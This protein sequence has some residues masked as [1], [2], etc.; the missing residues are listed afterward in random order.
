MQLP[1]YDHKSLICEPLHISLGDAAVRIIVGCTVRSLICAAALAWLACFSMDPAQA[2]TTGS[3]SGTVTD[4]KTHR[5]IGGVRVTAISPTSTLKTTADKSGFFSFIGVSPD[6]YTVSFDVAGYTPGRLTGVAVF[7]DQ[8]AS[9]SIELGLAVRLLGTVT[10]RGQGGAFQPLQT[11]NTYTVT[12]N[13]I[14]L[15][16]GKAGNINETSLLAAL[17]GVSLDISGYPVLRGGRQNEEGYEFEGIENTDAFA[18][19]FTNDL[20]MSGTGELQ[21]TPG[22]GD[23]SQG[24]FGT[25]IINLV[26]KRGT[27]PPFGTLETDVGYPAYYHQLAFEYGV[28]TPNSRFSDYMSFTGVRQGFQLGYAGTD[29]AAINQ[30]FGPQFRT[31]DE[32]VNNFFYKFGPNNNQALQLFVDWSNHNH[33]NDYGG[34]ST[35]CYKTCDHLTLDT[36]SSLSGLTQAQIQNMLSVLAPGAQTQVVQRLSDSGDIQIRPNELYKLQYFWNADPSTFVTAKYYVANWVQSLHYTFYNSS[37]FGFSTQT[38]W[39]GFRF[40]GAVD[41]T[42]QLSAKHLL[43]LGGKYEWIRPVYSQ[44]DNVYPFYSIAGFASGLE[45]YDYVSPSDPNCPLGTDPSGKSYCGY[46]AR[47]FPNGIPRLGSSDEQFIT[48]EQNFSG[49]IVDV[50]SPVSTVRINLGARVDA[51]N[52]KLPGYDSGYYLP[53]GFDAAGNPLY[54]YDRQVQY[55]RVFEPNIGVSWQFRPTDGIHLAYA[56][57]VEFPALGD[58]DLTLTRA[59]YAIYQNIPSYDVAGAAAGGL[60]AGAPNPAMYCGVLANQRCAN[61]ADQLFWENQLTFAG[62]PIEPI[63]PETFSNWEMSY[64]HQFSGNVGLRV[65]PFYRRGYD[66]LAFVAQPRTNT[67]G[68]VIRD[69]NG[70]LV[71]LPPT[72]TNLGMERTAGV[73]LLLTKDDAYGFSGHVAVTYVNGFSNVIPTSPS[74]DFF[75]SIPTPSVKLGNLYRIGYIPP[76][77][78][79][80]AIQYKWHSGFRVD[81]VFQYE[82]GYP[83]GSGLLTAYQWNGMLGNVPNTNGTSPGALGGSTGAPGYIDPGNPG[84]IPNPNIVATRGTSERSSPGGILSAPKLNTNFT[85][86]YQSPKT[87]LIFGAE[88]FNVFN[89]VYTPP[90]INTTWQPVA[91]GIGGPL[92]GQTILATQYPGIGYANYNAE[93]FGFDP[94]LIFPGAPSRQVQFYLRTSL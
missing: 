77:S 71:L 51:A 57:S 21:L 6:T 40:G 27:Y 59:P 58:I 36:M 12:N 61:Y 35:L 81:P 90:A 11:Q 66:A 33:Y 19:L 31:D 65:T 16:Q 53:T 86:E 79:S 41:F 44:P 68:Q 37:P 94:Y 20:T 69:A 67:Q 80:A 63:K 28:A 84:T 85:V 47:F 50:W 48:H 43:K 87:G 42:K 32:T 22:A 62:V 55:P 88:V 9:A 30:F 23:G 73:E 82:G 64:S 10:T 93:A 78:A 1:E 45:I 76:L 26:S 38:Q 25:G 18:N 17:P 49:Y 7:A 5:G 89:N 15:I 8:V 2:G 56:R 75:P 34:F 3:I 4:L 13:Q 92:T 29:A 60:P 24:N 70:N 14:N 46:L 83:L 91:T 74:E 54:N 72:S 39:G 52:F